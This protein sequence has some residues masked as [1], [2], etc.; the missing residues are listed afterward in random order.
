MADIAFHDF[1]DSFRRRLNGLGYSLRD[2]ERKWPGTDR[3]MLSRATNGKVLSAGNYLLLCEMAGL[4]PYLYFERA[5][6]KRTT[7]K[8]IVKQM[9]TRPVSCETEASPCC[10]N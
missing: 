9:V 10:E 2:A 3:A 7:M 8:T 5:K 6:R 4:D 1:A